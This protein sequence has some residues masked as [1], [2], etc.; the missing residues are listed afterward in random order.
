MDEFDARINP[1][2]VSAPFILQGITYQ[3]RQIE[4]KDYQQIVRINGETELVFWMKM[5]V[6]T[7]TLFTNSPIG[8][9][10]WMTGF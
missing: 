3:L 4:G 6:R 2:D 7:D 5:N 10:L 1:N 9:L 8:V